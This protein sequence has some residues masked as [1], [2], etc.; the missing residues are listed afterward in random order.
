MTYECSSVSKNSESE[1]WRL[2]IEICTYVKKSS[3]VYVFFLR[4]KF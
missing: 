3:E 4:L 2:I 1:C